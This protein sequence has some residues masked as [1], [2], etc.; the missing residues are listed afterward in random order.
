MKTVEERFWSKVEKAGPED[1]W[2]WKAG[3][4]LNGYGQMGA[5]GNGSMSAHRVSWI[6]THGEIPPGLCVCHRCD[7]RRCV[8]PEH[9]FLGTRG[10]NNRDAKAKGRSGVGERNGQSKLNAT[11][12]RRIR[13]LYAA[14]NFNQRQLSEKYGVARS[15]ISR[16]V[17]GASWQSEPL[18]AIPKGR[19]SAS[20]GK[21]TLADVERIVRDSA[22]GVS[23]R[24]LAAQHGVTPTTI[25]GILTGKT[26]RQVTASSPDNHRDLSADS[27][28]GPSRE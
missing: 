17:N 14:G 21:L 1:C 10:D 8:N 9:L 13:K 22:K 3:R 7:N 19:R 18:V 6:L 15:I 27:A 24:R 28:P 2:N 25:Y 20:H 26:W 11:Q 5:F 16:V 4:L 23:A 12:V